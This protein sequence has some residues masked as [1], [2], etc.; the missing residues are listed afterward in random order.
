MQELTYEDYKKYG[1]TSDHDAFL[2]LRTD[3]EAEL[4]RQTF[5]RID[6]L[7]ENIKRCMVVIMDGVLSNN[8]MKGLTSYSNGFES[9]GFGDTNTESGREKAIRTICLKYLPKELTYRG[10]LK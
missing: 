6:V 3:C 4:K 1:G 7:D 10:G 2:L 9:F 8:D 5:G